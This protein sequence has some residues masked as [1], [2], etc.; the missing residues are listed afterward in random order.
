MILLPKELTKFN[1]HQKT[2]LKENCYKLKL[3]NYKILL[4]GWNEFG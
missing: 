3:I 1:P 2:N 4:L